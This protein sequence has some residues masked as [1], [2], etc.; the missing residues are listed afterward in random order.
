MSRG[1]RLGVGF[2]F[3]VVAVLRALINATLAVIPNTA[4]GLSPG[5]RLHGLSWRDSFKWDNSV[6]SARSAH[7]SDELEQENG[8]FYVG[9]AFSDWNSFG[10]NRRFRDISSII[11]NERKSRDG[12]SR[13]GCCKDAESAI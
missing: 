10:C 12:P 6:G 3:L 5:R 8:V 4:H 1:G 9:S 11:T 13:I 2:E 7:D